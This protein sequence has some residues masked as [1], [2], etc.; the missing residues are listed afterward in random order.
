MFSLGITSFAARNYISFDRLTTANDRNQVVHRQ[1]PW[2][3][4]AAAVMA[5]AGG[6]FALPPLAGSQLP[7]LLA[8]AANFLLADFDEKRDWFHFRLRREGLFVQPI[9]TSKIDTKSYRNH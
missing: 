8:L 7:R 9:Q 2:W 4:F 5:H 6:K 1:L 3:K